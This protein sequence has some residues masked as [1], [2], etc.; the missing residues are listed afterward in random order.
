MAMIKQVY[1]GEG[2]ALTAPDG[3][4]ALVYF[5]GFVGGRPTNFIRLVVDSTDVDGGEREAPRGAGIDFEL[6]GYPCEVVFHG[7][8]GGD[9]PRA[10]INLRIHAPRAVKIEFV[11]ARYDVAGRS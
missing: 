7:F 2:V 3:A 4:E 5:D 1:E 11:D 9:E 10:Q 8:V 6:E